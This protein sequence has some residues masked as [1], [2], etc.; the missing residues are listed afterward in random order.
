MI[1]R[2]FITWRIDAIK[3]GL[4]QRLK[5]PQ[6]ATHNQIETTIRLLKAVAGVLLILNFFEDG[7][8]ARWVLKI[9]VS[10]GK[11]RPDVG[12]PGQLTN[13]YFPGIT[14][15][16]WRHVLVGFWIAQYSRDMYTTFMREGRRPN[17]RLSERA[18]ITE[19]FPDSSRY[20]REVREVA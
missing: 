5:L 7:F 10:I 3:L 1:S 12:A 17:K 9:G 19:Q 2:I 6:M 16:V 15:A 4:E 11:F 18:V 13:Q 20:P 14:D 8:S